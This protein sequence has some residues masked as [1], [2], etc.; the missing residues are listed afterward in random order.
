MYYIEELPFGTQSLFRIGN[1]RGDIVQILP[2]AG[3]NLH[4]LVLSG[5]TVVT[6]AP[7]LEEFNQ[8]LSSFPGAQLCPFPGRISK[9][10]YQFEGEKYE[11]DQ[12]DLAADNAIHG[13]VY[14]KQFRMVDSRIHT[15]LAWVSFGCKFEGSSGYPFKFYIENKYLLENSSLTIETTIRNTDT[16]PIPMAHGWHAYFNLEKP[17]NELFLDLPAEKYLELNDSMIPTGNVR[18]MKRES[19]QIDKLELDDCF[20]LADKDGISKTL[21]KSEQSILEVWQEQGDEGYNYLVVYT[22]SDR[23]SIA[24]EPMTCSPDAFNT[25]HGLIVLQPDTEMKLRT[26]VVLQKVQ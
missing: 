7:D 8:N 5:E 2:F 21:L 24:I 4:E 11:L 19:S 20:V 1:Q 9:G 10:S 13:L 15:D 18:S 17:I 22:P 26:G 3:A 16:Q 12:N 23:R 14:D 25:G 6:G